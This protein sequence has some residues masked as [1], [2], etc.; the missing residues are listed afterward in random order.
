MAPVHGDKLIEKM[1]RFFRKID[2]YAHDGQ[3]GSANYAM[4]RLAQIRKV[5]EMAI[6]HLEKT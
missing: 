6:R 4:D 2:E 1:R 5:A 3:N